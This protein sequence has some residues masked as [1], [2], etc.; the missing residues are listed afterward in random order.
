M[1]INPTVVP[2]II[3]GL[4]SIAGNIISNRGQKKRE[5]ERRDYDTKQWERVTAYNHPLEQMK[6][7]TEAGL[8]PNLIYGSSPGSAVG[9]AGAIPAGQAPNYRIDN[10]MVPFM[11]TKVK[12]AQSNNLNTAAIKNITSAN[13]NKA[14]TKQ[15]TDLLTGQVELQNESL[16]Q[17]RIKTD[18][19]R[20][21]SKAMSDK[22]TGIAVRYA[23]ETS[24]LLLD[25]QIKEAQ[26]EVQK[27]NKFLAQNGIRPG[28]PLW[29]RF[30][31]VAFNKGVEIT[32]QV[33]KEIN[34][35][36]NRLKQ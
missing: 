30:F 13:L 28:D 19:D 8:N 32:E 2:S 25:N 15:L 11:D 3:G 5:Q 16:K 4:G 23:T 34:E 33:K 18:V 12:Q 22:K 27:L 10:P 31:G 20:L 14:Q 35:M 24:N 36:Y 9:N 17:S 7:L 6:R 21:K 26:T 1:A 29:F